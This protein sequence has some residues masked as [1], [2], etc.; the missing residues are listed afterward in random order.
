MAK[1]REFEEEGQY[2]TTDFY[3]TAVL[4]LKKFEV[5]A[6]KSAG[7]KVKRFAFNDTPELRATILSYMNGTM[8]GNLREF[9]N[10][11]ECVKDMVHS[12]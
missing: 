4:V 8:E 11:I 3:T 2:T 5:L 12:G 10:A 7:G 6:I 9:R 1:E